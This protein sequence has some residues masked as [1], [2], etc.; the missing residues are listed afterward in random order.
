MK[1]A[2]L[3]VTIFAFTVVKSL[4][5]DG[6]ID[7]NY[8]NAKQGIPYPG[9]ASDIVYEIAKQPNQQFLIGGNFLYFNNWESHFICRIDSNGK[10]DTSFLSQ[11][12]NNY[13][14]IKKIV[15]LTDGKI[16]IGGAFGIARLHANGAFDSSFNQLGSG[17]NGHVSDILPINNNKIII[18]GLFTQYNSAST[19]YLACLNQNGTIDTAFN[20][21]GNGF[22]LPVYA[23]ARSKN[24]K[25]LA[26]GQFFIYNGFA[27]QYLIQL[28]LN[29]SRD[30][31]FTPSDL[32]AGVNCLQT[33]KNGRIYAGGSFG[34]ARLLETGA[35][36]STFNAVAASSNLS[37]PVNKIKILPNDN[38]LLASG[39]YDEYIR[40]WVAQKNIF[41]RTTE[42]NDVASFNYIIPDNA[43]EVYQM[44]TTVG[45][46]LLV[47]QNIFDRMYRSF[48]VAAIYHSALP[49]FKINRYNSDGSVDYTFNTNSLAKGANKVIRAAAQQTDGKTIVGG[50]FYYFNGQRVNRL[51]RLNVDGT[52]DNTFQVGDGPDKP[53]MDIAIQADGKILLSGFVN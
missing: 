48:G 31:T 40:Y 11:L 35:A 34:V 51:M 16:L 53:V 18:A 8:N 49:T 47:A 43:E 24:N 17:A 23:L 38:F 5:Q 15:V 7:L 30:T 10:V 44:E 29:G 41:M 4:A 46:K 14:G 3:F 37:G 21:T 1:R 28:N 13:F 26:G 42:G 52:I 19:P 33:D 9:G 12:G 6:T 39:Y 36:D 20:R 22:D 27:S 45:G 32:A 25:I 2:F 50:S